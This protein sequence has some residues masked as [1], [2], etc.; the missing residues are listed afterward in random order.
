MNLSVVVHQV[1]VQV[2]DPARRGMSLCCHM[3]AEERG[4]KGPDLAVGRRISFERV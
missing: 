3:H 4:V 2:K 1:T